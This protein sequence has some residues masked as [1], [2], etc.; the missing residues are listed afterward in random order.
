MSNV[1][2]DEMTAGE[3]AYEAQDDKDIKCDECCFSYPE[4]DLV[5]TFLNEHVCDT[6]LEDNY[7]CCDNCGDRG[8]RLR[9]EWI[10]DR[11]TGYCE[12]FQVCSR[13]NPIRGD[14]G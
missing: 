9:T 11:D 8:G 10:T 14:V 7:K 5:S 2:H 4:R 6:C 13:C 1:D 12:D 3:A